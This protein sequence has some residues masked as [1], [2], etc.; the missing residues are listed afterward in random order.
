MSG[1]SP[2][3][4]AETAPVA[5]TP[6][7]PASTPAMNP[8]PPAEVA[9]PAVV[10]PPEVTAPAA[11]VEE[12]PTPPAKEPPPATSL[13]ATAGKEDAKPTPPVEAEK[14]VPPVESA[15]VKYEPFKLPEGFQVDEKDMGE[16][17]GILGEAKVPQEAGQKLVDLYVR[18]M[19]KIATT[20]QASWQKTLDD[21]KNDVLADPELGGNRLQTVLKRCGSVLEQFGTPELRKMLEVSGMGNNIEMVRFVNKVAEF[22]G[23]PKPVPAQKP[24]PNVK[25]S[26]AQR[27]YGNGASPP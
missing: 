19:E 18:E 23:E 17:T 9:A 26:R 24:V 5:A 20:Q 22:V 3:P 13:L 10:V 6:V 12:A 1:N 14:P 7:A 2:I 27:R 15:P 11:K 25:P 4:A 8:S 16:L 21:W